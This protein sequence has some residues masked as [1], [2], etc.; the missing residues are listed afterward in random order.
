L[1]QHITAVIPAF[2]EERS[3]EDAVK[4]TLKFV[5]QVL[6]VDDHSTDRTYALARK[7]GA[8]V[9]QNRYE[10][11]PHLA[12]LHGIKF[13]NSE[14]IVTLDADGQQPPRDIPRLL[15]PILEDNADYAI[16]RREQLPP[17]EKPIREVVKDVLAEELDAGSGFRAFRREFLSNSKPSDIGFCSCGSFLLLAR[18][19]GARITEV[20][21]HSNPRKFGGSKI[22]RRGKY[23]LHRR[24]AS[25]LRRKYGH[26]TGR[27]FK[28]IGWKP[29]D[30]R[31]Q[32]ASLE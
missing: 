7:A 29:R 30:Y 8:R 22:A 21:Y 13:A 18:K 5:D 27:S 10:R 32:R 17:S 20:T 11:K 19:N 1:R 12:I 2:N 4:R 15:K 16:G 24:Q 6:V 3:I 31:R 14:I 23:A 26:S 9:I 28:G 25:F